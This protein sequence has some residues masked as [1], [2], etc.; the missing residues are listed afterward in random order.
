MQNLT[1][2]FN[3]TF[4]YLIKNEVVKIAEGIDQ[5]V[6]VDGRMGYTQY[7]ACCWSAMG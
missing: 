5:I 4:A 7:G 2:D 6:A 1:W 3:A